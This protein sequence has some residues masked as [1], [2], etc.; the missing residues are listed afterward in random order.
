MYKLDTLISLL[1]Q[2]H[3][4]AEDLL[5]GVHSKADDVLHRIGDLLERLPDDLLIQTMTLACAHPDPPTL[6]RGLL[7]MSQINKRF[8]DLALGMTDMWA[9]GICPETPLKLTEACIAR[10]KSVGL[11]ISLPV[12]PLTKDE[13]L[14]VEKILSVSHRW[15][16]VSIVYHDVFN[17]KQLSKIRKLLAGLQL[18]ILERL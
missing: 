3:E 11:R 7:S 8:R 2:L 6:T 9:S 15:K 1:G 14:Y 4:T 18:P 17:N 10:S 13:R 12:S 5:R 16:E